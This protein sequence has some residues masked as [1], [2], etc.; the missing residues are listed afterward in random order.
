M[1]GAVFFLK[2]LVVLWL[3]DGVGDQ[4]RSNATPRE[5]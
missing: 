4:R 1:F 2:N 5:N 3:S